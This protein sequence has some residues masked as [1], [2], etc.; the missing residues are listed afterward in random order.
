MEEKAILT[1]DMFNKIMTI[2]RKAKAE[3]KI[4]KLKDFDEIFI[5]M[6]KKEEIFYHRSSYEIRCN[7]PR[8]LCETRGD[9]VTKRELEN[10]TKT[11]LEKLD[12]KITDIHRHPEDILYQ[13]NKPTDQTSHLHFI[14]KDKSEH[15]TLRILNFVKDF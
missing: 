14:C 15:D 1:D 5:D 10:N 13:I 7:K 8:V 2:F 6:P 11:S 12:C 9:L 4:F 3:P